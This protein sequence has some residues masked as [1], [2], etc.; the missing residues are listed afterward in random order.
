MTSFSYIIKDEL[1]FH[2]R[3]AGFFAKQ[4]KAFQSSVS[5]IK[6]EKRCDGKKLMMI[7]GMGIKGGDTIRV[8]C[9]GEDEKECAE[10]LERFLKA[11]L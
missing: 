10:E 7:M 2:A 4:A 9:S 8:E 5:I 3:P 1:G 11:N 6:G